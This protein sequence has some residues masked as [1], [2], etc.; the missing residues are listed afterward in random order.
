MLPQSTL[1]IATRSMVSC[2]QE[3]CL[4]MHTH[5]ARRKSSSEARW[6]VILQM[7]N[8]T[9]LHQQHHQIHLLWFNHAYFC[10]NMDLMFVESRIQSAYVFI[11]QA[12][13]ILVTVN[14]SRKR[15]YM[16]YLGTTMGVLTTREDVNEGGTWII[17]RT[18]TLREFKLSKDSNTRMTRMLRGLEYSRGLER[19]K[20]LKR[21]QGL[22]RCGSCSEVAGT[23]AKGS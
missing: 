6:H 12:K 16:F 19:S 20:G 18:R 3:G 5:K 13:D 14:I 21:C 4:Q 8:P 2:A 9:T 23:K 17:K 7:Q 11:G 15:P 1:T 22:E 10:D